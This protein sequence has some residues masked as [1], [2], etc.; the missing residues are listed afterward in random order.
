VALEDVRRRDDTVRLSG[1]A[2]VVGATTPMRIVVKIDGTTVARRLARRPRPELTRVLGTGDHG[3]FDLRIRLPRASASGR[4][5]LTVIA[6]DPD[7]GS[8]TR[9]ARRVLRAE[10]ST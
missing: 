6:V 3:G 8:R 4:L 2:A 1:Y 7:T 5:N 10:V 9:V